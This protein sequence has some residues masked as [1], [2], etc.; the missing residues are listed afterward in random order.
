M[1]LAAV[2]LLPGLARAEITLCDGKWT[3]KPCASGAMVKLPEVTPT[4][5]KMTST[6]S[7][8]KEILYRSLERRNDDVRARYGV[9]VSLDDARRI[10]F[11]EEST[12]EQ[13]RQSIDLANDALRARTADLQREH[14][15]THVNH[16]GSGSE[17]SEDTK[18]VTV[19]QQN[20]GDAL[21]GRHHHDPRDDYR[22]LT[23]R[24]P[25]QEFNNIPPGTR[26]LGVG[27]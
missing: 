22:V 27:R 12:L 1:A 6:S 9:S 25:R 21:V 7:V 23:D 13:C 14:R 26:G 4:P 15:P 17:G 20:N 3:N 10:C 24:P 5:G 2:A 19:V 18:N 16:Q 8:S 11:E